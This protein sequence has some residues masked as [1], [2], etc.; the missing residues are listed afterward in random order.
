[1]GYNIMKWD[2]DDSIM[3]NYL[4]KI[5][6]YQENR[7]SLKR[8]T[9]TKS[10]IENRYKTSCNRVNK[11]IKMLITS[12]NFLDLYQDSGGICNLTGIKLTSITM[13][14]RVGFRNM[15]RKERGPIRRKE[16]S[17]DYCINNIQLV[18]SIVNIM[19]GEM[20]M[21][22]FL[23]FCKSAINYDSLK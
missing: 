6:T 14:K 9:V 13:P 1:M 19:K 11:S 8:L 7:A 21:E 10:F 15:S 5:V 2:I 3:L 16:T 4:Q 12:N 22:T 23:D 18:C 20:S 17:K